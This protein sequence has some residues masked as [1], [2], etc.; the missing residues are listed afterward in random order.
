MGTMSKSLTT[1]RLR[2]RHRSGTYPAPSL[3]TSRYAADARSHS[4]V[5]RTAHLM[6]HDVFLTALVKATRLYWHRYLGVAG[7]WWRGEGLVKA[8][9]EYGG[10]I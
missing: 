2:P 7:K 6:V 3:V 1:T 5:P 10:E 9:L 8:V 4:R